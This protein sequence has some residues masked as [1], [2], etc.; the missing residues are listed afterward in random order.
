MAR[1]KPTQTFITDDPLS[2]TT[3]LYQTWR[4]PL[5]FQGFG[6]LHFPAANVYIV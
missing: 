6:L 4:A 1:H 5:P 3:P 2:P